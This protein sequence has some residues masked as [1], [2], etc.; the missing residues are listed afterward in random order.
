MK[1]L[2]VQD[3][4]NLG[5]AGD[6]KEVANGYGRN[7]LIPNGLAVLAKAGA[8]KEADVHRRKAAER[9]ERI[10]A[11]MTAM[12]EVISQVELTFKAKAGEK[13]RLYGSVTAA[14]ITEKLAE[15]I[16][17]EVDR[18]KIVLEGPIKEL[19][20]HRVSIRLGPDIMTT[21]GVVVEPLEPIAEEEPEP[22]EEPAAQQEPEMAE[23]PAAAE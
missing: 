2:L 11:E 5:L 16:G 21:F 23:E 7:Y 18:R 8:L 9:R 14:E 22:A 20:T 12:A 10:A 15:S 1:V 4:D 17:H 3:V 13:G 6:V 19:G